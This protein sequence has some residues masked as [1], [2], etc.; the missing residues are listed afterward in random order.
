MIFLSPLNHHHPIMSLIGGG[1]TGRDHIVQKTGH[2]AHERGFFCYACTE[3]VKK[4]LITTVS[5]PGINPLSI[6]QRKPGYVK[7]PL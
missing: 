5:I 2:M 1:S 6:T 3:E 4:M 7:L